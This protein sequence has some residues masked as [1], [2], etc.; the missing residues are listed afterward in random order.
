MIR[1]ERSGTMHGH[2]CQPH[3]AVF[4]SSSRKE[5]GKILYS[6]TSMGILFRLLTLVFRLVVFLLAT[7]AGKCGSGS[8]PWRREKQQRKETTK[9]QRKETTKEQ[10]KEKQ[11][12]NKGN[13]KEN[14]RKHKGNAKEK[15]RNKQRNKQRKTKQRKTKQRK[16]RRCCRC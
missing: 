7:A 6:R 1:Q 3:F 5:K 8:G 2:A 15:Q 4:S 12:K 14:Q 10:T 11:R 16:Y 9:E 13:A